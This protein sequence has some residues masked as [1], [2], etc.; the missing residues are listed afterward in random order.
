MWG[1][2]PEGRSVTGSRAALAMA[3]RELLPVGAAM[4]VAPTSEEP[5]KVFPEEELAVSSAIAG[6]RREFALGR[7]CARRALADLGVAATPVLVGP[8]REPLWPTGVTGSISHC[9]SW[10]VAVVG[11]SSRFASLGVDVE[12]A[13]PLARGVAEIIS[14]PLERQQLTG[15]GADSCAE[16]L[17]F[18]V[19]ECVYKAWYPLTGR[20]LG[21][22]AAAVSIDW[23]RR[24]FKA[25]L[26]SAEADV[27]PAFEGR[28]ARFGDVW[29]T[30]IAVPVGP[31]QNRDRSGWKAISAPYEAASPSIEM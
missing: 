11:R 22:E 30:A 18:S 1:L 21:F 25:S 5:S 4:A 28:F 31:D 7:T 24:S 26:L 27:R 19:K 23:S 14:T 12:P 17:L 29:L 8:G 16:A 2:R 20:W 13:A 10:C 6:R 9:S 3:L 15:R